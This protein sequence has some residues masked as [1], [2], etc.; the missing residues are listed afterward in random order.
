M[1]ML[2]VLAHPSPNSFN[3]ALAAAAAD[4]ARS[5]GH[6]VEIS[7]LY[8]EG[9][10]P[11]GGPNDFITPID[12]GEFHYQSAQRTA[13]LENGFSP[14]IRREQD[15]VR[16][17]DCLLLQFPLWWGGPP[18]ILKGWIDRVCAY[19]ITYADGTRFDTGLFRGR[20]SLLSVTTGGTPRRFSNDGEYG[21]IEQVLYSTQHL[22]LAYMG[23]D[24][25]TPQVSYGVAR[26]DDA[27]RD[28][29]IEALRARV[30]DLLATPIE[31]TP[32]PSPDVLLASVGTRSWNS[33]G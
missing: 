33:A 16:E 18:A 30:R 3:A 8:A 6:E 20:R 9:F 23:Y 12:P 19:G 22:F 28:G 31:A 15:R 1:K 13:A 24:L 11:A 14:E 10:S 17:A 26:E 7:D 4:E 21:P 27:A 2:I 29:M 5:L 32:V 25:A